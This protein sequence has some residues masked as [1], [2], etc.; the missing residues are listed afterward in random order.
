M[1]DLT[2][3]MR[4]TALESVDLSGVQAAMWHRRDGREVGEGIEDLAAMWPRLRV[5]VL[6]H[7]PLLRI[8]SAVARPAM[9]TG[10]SCVPADVQG[11]FRNQKID[12]FNFRRF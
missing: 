6:E 4:C 3:L 10:G 1:T 7:T 5:L 12:T 11:H 8:W 2:P 9:T